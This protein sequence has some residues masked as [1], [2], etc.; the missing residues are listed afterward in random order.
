MDKPLTL[1]QVI[2]FLLEAPLFDSLDAAELSE[3]VQI[4]QLQAFRSG[5][6]VFREGDD[7]D[8][9]Y[10]L[11]SGRG[12]VTKESPFGPSQEIAVLEPKSCFGEMAILDG[13]ERSATVRAEG[14]TQVFRFPRAPFQKLLDDGKLGAYKLVLA[15]AQ[16]LCQ[17]Q[18]RITA[19]L[20]ELM[21]EAPEGGELV[22]DQMGEM[23]DEYTV[24]E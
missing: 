4:M 23:L 16:V 21:E 3:V 22:R 24:S 11:F 14:D 17:R 5:Q 18:R 6:A 9:W 20:A 8:A 12:I 15:M 10:V 13:S 2:S 1:E 19:K 7:G